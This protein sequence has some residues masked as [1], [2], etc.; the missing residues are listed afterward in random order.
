MIKKRINESLV[1]FGAFLVGILCMMLHPLRTYFALPV[2]DF[3]FVIQFFACYFFGGI[4]A[5]VISLC[6]GLIKDVLYGAIV[7]PSILLSILI[8]AAFTLIHDFWTEYTI[9][10]SFI[11]LLIFWLVH[12]ILKSVIFA[13][14]PFFAFAGEEFAALLRINLIEGVLAI[15]GMVIAQV[16]LLFYFTFTYRDFEQ[17]R[18]NEA[19][20]QMYI[21]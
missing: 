14:I 10:K 4:R 19:M 5:I 16:V 11:Y 1:W 7:G 3:L 2:T 13:L 17:F 18:A 20:A 6:A 12:K 21:E 15:P 9:K 8:L